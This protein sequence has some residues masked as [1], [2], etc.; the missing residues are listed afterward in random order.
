MTCFLILSFYKCK[1]LSSINIPEGVVEIGDNAFNGCESL[2]SVVIPESVVKIGITAFNGCRGMTSL[3]I[4]ANVETFGRRVFSGC[5]AIENLTIMGD[6]MADIVSEKITKVTLFSPMPFKASK[7]K[8]EVYENA[9]L[10]VPNGSLELYR[11]ADVWKE[12]KNIAEFDPTGIDDIIVDEAEAPIYTLKGERVSGTRATLPAGMY[13]Q[14]GKK[15]V[16]M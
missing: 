14:G 3:T 7:F 12:F 10:Y 16:V 5:T 1:N 13:I 4:G 8:D 6:K 11:A 9:T 15:F 2:I